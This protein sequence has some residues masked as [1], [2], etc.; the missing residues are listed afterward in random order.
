MQQV[1]SDILA[2]LKTPFVGDLDVTHLFILV[3]VV[4]VFIAAWVFILNH[5]RLAAAAAT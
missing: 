5:I 2:M 1:W 3:G 4:L